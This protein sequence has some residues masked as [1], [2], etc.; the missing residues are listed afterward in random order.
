MKE[1]LSV[2]EEGKFVKMIAY[3][4]SPVAR[5][6]RTNNHLERCN[7]KLRYWEKVRYKWRCR[8]SLGRFLVLA[9]DHWWKK[10]LICPQ[11]TSTDTPSADEMTPQARQSP[12]REQPMASGR[13]AA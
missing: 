1:A 3:L 7:R 9:L 6:V 11:T 12:I 13:K 8:R 4:R 2:L 5:R 10:V